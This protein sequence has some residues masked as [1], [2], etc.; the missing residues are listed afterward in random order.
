M[1]GGVPIA[2]TSLLL[3]V[4]PALGPVPSSREP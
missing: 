3:A 2:S 1:V 4:A